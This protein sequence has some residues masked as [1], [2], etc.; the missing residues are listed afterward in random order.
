MYTSHVTSMEVSLILKNSKKEDKKLSFTETESV[1]KK[2]G[3][4]HDTSNNQK[5]KRC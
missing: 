5:H 3:K 2:I 1:R 4:D